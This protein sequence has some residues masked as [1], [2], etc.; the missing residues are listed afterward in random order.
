[1]TSERSKGSVLPR[2][3]ADVISDFADL[4]LKEV[5]LAKAELSA[6]CQTNCEPGFGCRRPPAWLSLL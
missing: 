1:M 5:R 2:A 3:F 4:V 6:S